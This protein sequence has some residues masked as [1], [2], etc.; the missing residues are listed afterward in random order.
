MARKLF[1]VVG[2]ASVIL[3]GIAIFLPTGRDTGPVVVKD[4][5]P[6]EQLEIFMTDKMDY[7]IRFS[8]LLAEKR[9]ALARRYAAEDPALADRAREVIDSLEARLERRAKM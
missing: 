8:R 4:D 5:P 2:I 7:G 9:I 1:L 6:A 3:L